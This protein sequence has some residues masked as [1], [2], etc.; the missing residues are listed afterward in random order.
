MQTPAAVSDKPLDVVGNC[1]DFLCGR[2]IHFGDRC[3][4]DRDGKLYCNE[5][6]FVGSMMAKA[7]L[8]GTGE[9]T[10]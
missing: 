1:A 8:A 3:I 4:Q 10:L 7:V 5:S 2:A 9:L 6:C